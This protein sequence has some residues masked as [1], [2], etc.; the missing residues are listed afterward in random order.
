MGKGSRGTYKHIQ[1][2]YRYVVVDRYDESDSDVI[3]YTADG[4]CIYLAKNWNGSHHDMYTV[5]ISKYRIN[6][7]KELLLYKLGG[8]LD[9]SDGMW[10]YFVWSRDNPEE[11]HSVLQKFNGEARQDSQRFWRTMRML[12]LNLRGEN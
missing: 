7:F 12:Y 5:L 9:L 6:F 11:T 3:D 4:H 2:A 10:Y 1:Q 8:S